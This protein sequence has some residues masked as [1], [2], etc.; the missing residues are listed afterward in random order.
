MSVRNSD[1]LG[2]GGRPAGEH[3]GLG[4]VVRPAQASVCSRRDQ[5]GVKARIGVIADTHCPEFL[6]ALP[7]WIFKSLRGVDVILHAGDVNGASTLE[8]LARIAPVEAVRGDHDRELGFLPTTR[9]LTIAGKK[10]ALVH[11][12]RARWLEELQTLL[13]T[14]SL[15]YFRPHKSLPRTLR[16][17]FPNADVIVF[18]HTHR[19]YTHMVGGALLFNPGGVHQWNA[20]TARHRLQQKPGW[21]EWSWLQFARHLRKVQQ[22]SIGIIEIDDE[23]L[24]PRIIGL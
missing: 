16:R 24:I 2:G 3:R 15:G 4:P 13:W 22:P 5:G 11:G 10:I 1:K 6:D 9:E 12:N 17:R 7:E 21:F 23:G 20:A 18:G 14:L 19:V 8:A